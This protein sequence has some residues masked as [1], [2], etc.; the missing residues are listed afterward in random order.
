MNTIWIIVITIFVYNL[1]GTVVLLLI[2]AK[3]E[4]SENFLVFYTTGF[5]GIPIYL[6][7]QLCRKIRKAV[8]YTYGC[9]IVRRKSDEYGE[10]ESIVCKAKDLP[11]FENSDN[12]ELVKRYA[13]REDISEGWYINSENEKVYRQELRYATPAEIYEV[14]NEINC[15]NCMHN[16]RECDDEQCLCKDDRYGR[17]IEYDKFE[18]E[19][20][21]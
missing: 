21:K 13:K 3:N 8:R 5:I 15:F 11:Y 9:A 1:I 10:F 6:L 14:R 20:K 7:F 17:V 2:E 16:G 4:D 19:K 12:Y 18:R